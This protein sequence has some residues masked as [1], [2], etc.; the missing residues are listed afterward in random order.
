MF[1]QRFVVQ[2]V[3]SSD[4]DSDECPNPI[5]DSSDDSESDSEKEETLCRRR[6][7]FSDS[8]E[9]ECSDEEPTTSD[10]DFIDDSDLAEPG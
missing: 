6:L 8:D 3:S 5:W 10:L 7:T 2:L 1:S 4:D 9:E